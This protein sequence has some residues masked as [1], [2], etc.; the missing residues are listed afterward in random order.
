MNVVKVLV[1]AALV[2]LVT[3]LIAIGTCG[4]LF[5]WVYQLNP[6]DVWKLG[7]GE[8]PPW[9]LHL[10]NFGL[11]IIL[12]LVYIVLMK[13]LPGKSRLVRGFAFGLCVW[14]VGLLPGMFSTF[15]FV[16]IAKE[17]VIYWAIQGLVVS[18]LSGI[19]IALIC[20]RC[21]CGCTQPEA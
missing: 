6:S 4:G 11:G 5:N 2:T 21:T 19:I 18:V 20:D 8:S 15:V 14:G 1:A 12:A 10:G 3:T 13:G 16:T 9:Y 7:P 17:V